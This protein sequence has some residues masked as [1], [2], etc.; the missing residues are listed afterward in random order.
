MEPVEHPNVLLILID[1]L[2]ADHVGCYGYPRDT[3]PA[4]DALARRGRRFLDAITPAP[5]SAP[6]MAALLAGRYPSSVDLT[7]LQA[8]LTSAVSLLPERAREVGYSTAAV[9]SHDFVSARWRLDQGF[10][11]FFEVQSEDPAQP[12]SSAVTDAALGLLDQLG[13]GPF[14]L[15]VHYADPLPDWL[16]I[17]GFSFA[18]P[19][20]QGAVVAGTPHGSLLRR[21]A[22]M[23]A[24]DRAQVV[25]H[26]DAEVAYTDRQVGRLLDGL[27]AR[28]R[29]ADTLVVLTSTHG[30]ELFDHGELGDAKTLYD[31]LVHVPL[32]MAG[33]GVEPGEES[34][35]VSLIDLAP[36]LAASMGLEPDL[37]VE[38]VAFWG[39]EVPA[40]R[41]L[42]SE[43]DR[44]RSLRS[45]TTGRWKL[46]HDLQRG[47]LQL[48][49]LA[50]DP[51][52]LDDLAPDGLGPVEELEASL[53]RWEQRDG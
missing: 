38:G 49:D 53:R 21:L 45:V 4:L 22:K 8:P 52:E 25:A 7:D 1:G 30:M 24:Q 36:T 11:D 42:F 20:Y 12:T 39:A 10:E 3:T 35:A 5:W 40:Q 13:K 2:R 47:T 51:E 15:L 28:G 14:L 18:D 32:V 33:P 9:V 48:Y 23:D 19:T 37:A 46:V 29:D 17:A 27:R 44:A 41:E 16:E 31:E 34:A 50:A 26:Y 43:T 6:A